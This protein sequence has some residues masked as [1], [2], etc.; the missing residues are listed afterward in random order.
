VRCS[1]SGADELANSSDAIQSLMPHWSQMSALSVLCL[2][3]MANGANAPVRT[4]QATTTN[5]SG[6][7]GVN[8]PIREAA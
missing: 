7:L 2:L 8:L 3:T 5:H 1:L 6:I 4:M